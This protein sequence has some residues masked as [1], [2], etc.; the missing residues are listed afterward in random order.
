MGSIKREPSAPKQDGSTRCFSGRP[1][2]GAGGACG[3]PEDGALREGLHGNRRVDPRS[4]VEFD[5]SVSCDDLF[6]VTGDSSDLNMFEPDNRE[7]NRLGPQM[8][9]FVLEA[10]D[11]M[12]LCAPD[13]GPDALIQPILSR[14]NIAKPLLGE[15]LGAH[16]AADPS[17]RY[18]ALGCSENVI[19]I[20]SLKSREEMDA[21]YMSGQPL[22]YIFEERSLS[23]KGVILKIEFLFPSPKDPDHIILLLL[24]SRNGKTRMHVYE[25]ISG[26][27]LSDIRQNYRKGHLLDECY[28]TPI[29]LIPLT[30]KS[31]F[32]LVCEQSVAVCEGLLEGSP[33][34]HQSHLGHDGPS[35]THKGRNAPLWT[36]WT[37]PARHKKYAATNDDI[38]IAREDGL[39]KYLE[40]NFDEF[41]CTGVSLG[42]ISCNIGTAFTSL[43]SKFLGPN[44]V[45]GDSDILLVGGDSCPGAVYWVSSCQ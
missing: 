31:A 8:I 34:C 20:Y 36:S 5:C 11:L 32:V 6:A 27:P 9:V 1:K 21:Q 3:E 38:Y 30:I 7:K 39:V 44:D 45:V 40:N 13:F 23:I 25:W 37:R 14:H 29:L 22:S 2:P 18:I 43:D 19:S 26:Q 42:G 4:L 17:S 33:Q 24:I 12:F 16:L 15:H 41:L 28:R 10:G 35:P